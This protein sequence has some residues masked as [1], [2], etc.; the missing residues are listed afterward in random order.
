MPQRRRGR[1]RNGCSFQNAGQ[2]V[3]FGHM[4][5][6]SEAGPH[7]LFSLPRLSFSQGGPNALNDRMLLKQAR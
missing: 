3:W 1:K 5:K 7:T 2:G 6:L 4:L